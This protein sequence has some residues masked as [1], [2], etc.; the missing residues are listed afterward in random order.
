MVK[1]LIVTGALIT[2]M[3]SASWSRL[4]GKIEAQD[5]VTLSDDE[6]KSDRQQFMRRKL[7]MVQNIVE[8]IA[9]EDFDLISK[10]GMEL[11]ALAE[12]ATW[13]STKDPYYRHYSA[14]FEQSAKGLLAAAKSESVEKATFAYVHVTFSCTACHQHVRGTVRVA[15]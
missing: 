10:G 15:R 3:I 14:N 11:L 1:R 2:V 5:D 13:K 9:V 6:S 7:S 8:G 4:S 12:S